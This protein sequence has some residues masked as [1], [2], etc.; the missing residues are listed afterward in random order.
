MKKRTP[1]GVGKNEPKR[2]QTNPISKEPKMNVNAYI[3]TSY[4]NY[5]A[6]RGHENKPNS[7]PILQK[8]QVNTNSLLI[9]DYESQPRSGGKSNSN[10]ILSEAKM[11]ATV[12]FTTNYENQP[13]RILPGRRSNF[14]TANEMTPLLRFGRNCGSMPT[15]CTQHVGW[16]R[17][18]LEN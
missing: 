13:L 3:T 14:E 4:E 1:G 17:D 16:G 6:L 18:I 7:N 8:A 12:Y 9:K 11:S 2:T 10:P 5:P 15:E